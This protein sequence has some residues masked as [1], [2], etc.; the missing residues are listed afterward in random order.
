MKMWLFS[1]GE[2]QMNPADL[3]QLAGVG[4]AGSPAYAV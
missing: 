2:C 4:W 3:Q 1:I